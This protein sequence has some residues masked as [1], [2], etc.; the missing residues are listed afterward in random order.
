MAYFDV[1]IGLSLFALFFIPA[2]LIGTALGV[3]VIA[4]LDRRFG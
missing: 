4:Y 3:I 1:V 2:A